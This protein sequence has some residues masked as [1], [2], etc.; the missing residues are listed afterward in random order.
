MLLVTAPPNAIVFGSGAIE[1]RQMLRVGAV[2]D[3]IGIVVVSL[4]I[5]T[6]G[7]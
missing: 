1:M 5:L 7:N 4:D 6:L 3:V 2:L